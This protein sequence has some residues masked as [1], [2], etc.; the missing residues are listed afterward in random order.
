MAS[1]IDRTALTFSSPSGRGDSAS[2]GLTLKGNGG[3]YS[4]DER[5]DGDTVV[6]LELDDRDGA[7]VL[8][9]AHH[10]QQLPAVRG[11]PPHVDDHHVG[12]TLLDALPR[13]AAV[14]V[15]EGDQPAGLAQHRR[16]VDG[17]VLVPR[18][19]K[20]RPR[21]PPII[22][23]P[24]RHSPEPRIS[25]AASARASATATGSRSPQ[26]GWTSSEGG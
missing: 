9:L 18:H 21:H 2:M 4:I 15:L 24:W 12:L 22:L 13:L 10:P 17:L 20:G 3:L 1:N 23:R 8:A 7:R 6:T 25:R 5:G 16:Q 14:G 26:G 11:P 19:H